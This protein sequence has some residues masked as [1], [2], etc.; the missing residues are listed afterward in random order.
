MKNYLLLFAILTISFLS[1]NKDDSECETNGT[2]KIN[3]ENRATYQAEVTVNMDTPFIMEPDEEVTLTLPIGAY[4]VTAVEV[5]GLM[6]STG[7]NVNLDLCST[8]NLV[9]GM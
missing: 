9:I 4:D 1:C 6:I 2:G 3:I 5:G 8:R 7:F